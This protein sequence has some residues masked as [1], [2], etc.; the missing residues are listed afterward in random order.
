MW[1]FSMMPL[2]LIP[3]SFVAEIA[4]TPIAFL[5]S[6]ILLLLSATAL[7]LLIPALRHLRPVIGEWASPTHAEAADQVAKLP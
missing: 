4:G 3:V 5:G 1:T 7:F 2:G 6:A